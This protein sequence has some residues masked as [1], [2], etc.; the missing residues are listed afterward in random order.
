MGLRVVR[1]TF[2]GVDPGRFN[3]LPDRVQALLGRPLNATDLARALR[4]VYA[5]GLFDTVDAQAAREGDGVLITFAGVPRTFIGEVNVAGAKGTSM[6][7][8]LERASGLAAG[9][10][11]TQAKFDTAVTRIRQTLAD[12]GFHAPKLSHSLTP[13]PNNKL[14]D[15]DFSV[16]SGPQARIGTV[17]AEGDAAMTSEQFQRIARMKPNA[18]VD[19]DTVNRALANMLKHFQRLNRLEAEIKLV[20]S[21]Y[22]AATRR[23][24]YVFSVN[25]GPIV[26]VKL[27]GAVMEPERFRR[28]IPV[29]EEGTVDEDLLN[30]G[31]RRLR[32]Y[33]QQLGY[34]D[35]AVTHEQQS[36]DAQQVTIVYHVVLG[37]RRRVTKV[38]IDGNKYFDEATLKDLLSVHPADSIDRHGTYSQALVSADES[39]IKAVYQ[40]NGFADVKV[41]ADTKTIDPGAA[42]LGEKQSKMP[43]LALTYHVDEGQQQKVGTVTLDGNT[44]VATT[45]LQALMN[46]ASGQLLSPESLA[47]DR[48]AL[49]NDYLNRGFDQ[50]QIDVE[51]DQAG[52]NLTNVVFHIT[53]GE[54][55]FVNDVLVT[56]LHYTRP[57]TVARAVTLHPGDPLNQGELQDTQRNLYDYALFNEVETAIENPTGAVAR[58]TVLVQTTEARR[59]SFTY[60]FGFETQTG[61]PQNNCAGY[62]AVG[63]SCTP[64]GRTGISP[65]VLGSL[66]RNNLFGRDQSAS[67]QGTYGLL[68][69]NIHLIYQNP[70]FF[71]SPNFALTF[72]GGYA[73]SQAVTTYVAS[74]FDI[75][76][77]VTQKFPPSSHRLFR[78]NTFVY[79]DAFRRVKVQ[80][81]S[82]QVYPAELDL[83][84]A[85]VR[86]SGPGI[87]WLRDTRDSTLDAHRGTFTSFQEFMSLRSLGAEIQFNRIDVT[88]SN[89]WSFG[90]KQFV[91]ARSTRFGQESIFGNS[92]DLLLPLPERLYSGGS[93]SLRGFGINGAGPRDPETGFPI[94]GAGV[95]TNNTELR[96]PAPTLPF[97]GNALSLVLFEDMGN[98]FAHAGDAWSSI[99]RIHQPNRDSC[100]VLFQ[101]GSIDN[102]P[103]PP[104]TPTSPVG[105]LGNCSS[106]YFT[107]TPGL[108]FRYHTP[109]GPV[110]LDFS[111]NLNPPIYPI[112]L[113]Y[114]KKDPFASP[115]VGEAGHFNF[116]FSLGQT[117]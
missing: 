30:E 94:G 33:Y 15:V 108:G 9:E 52:A 1:V 14:I 49:L 73:N 97:V 83:L 17:T 100:K 116:F 117:F 27:D 6:D 42:A 82:L 16:D 78:G 96:L 98:V 107:H 20:S 37:T 59:W 24:N 109:V 55:V 93:T 35:V 40:N 23:T 36:S 45:D 56:G 43:G 115:H 75:G 4:A 103:T 112:N 44:H 113:D 50:A 77:R 7:A 3:P 85:S 114:S 91:L 19:R 66:T 69:Q 74:K 26:H 53:E 57:S 76:I 54:Q 72:T 87:T 46:T 101:N 70:R 31:G 102:Q 64:G 39:S 51:Q 25:Q 111:Y 5:A 68:E 12:N 8:Q 95:L 32:D 80:K 29:Y 89:Y 2:D 99:V 67:L 58:K 11:F 92:A 38:W 86:V 81:S 48:D 47:G 60:G 28:N 61:T 65:R 41:T 84:S 104:P 62:L 90:K 63:A 106:N 105:P 22:D 79:E 10:R 88:N 13:H 110:R 71:G 18:L 21:Q 34:F